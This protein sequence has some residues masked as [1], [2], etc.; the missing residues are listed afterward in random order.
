MHVLHIW[1]IS[2]VH[3]LHIPGTWHIH[4]VCVHKSPDSVSGA[5]WYSKNESRIYLRPSLRSCRMCHTHTL[6]LSLS[7]SL[8]LTHTHTHTHTS[9]P[10][11]HRR[12]RTYTRAESERE[13]GW[14][15]SN[16]Q[17]FKGN[18]FA[19]MRQGQSVTVHVGDVCLSC[20]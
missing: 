8:S 12:T 15:K 20:Y 19:W 1:N 10:H 18:R 2:F 9:Y 17:R 14:G 6:S 4:Q 16:R 13:R 3:V 5:T 11:R 7:L